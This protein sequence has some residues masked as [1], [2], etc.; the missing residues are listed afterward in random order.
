MENLPSH[1]P[2]LKTVPSS[3]TRNFLTTS[4]GRFSISLYLSFWTIKHQFISLLN[5][6]H[7]MKAIFQNAVFKMLSV[8]CGEMTQT[9]KI[10]NLTNNFTRNV[11][12]QMWPLMRPNWCLFTKLGYV[13]LSILLHSLL[14]RHLANFLFLNSKNELFKRNRRY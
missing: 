13:F 8:W 9:F 6:A 11:Q 2:T 14:I 10:V 5:T 7:P 4:L 1:A 3:V 12:N